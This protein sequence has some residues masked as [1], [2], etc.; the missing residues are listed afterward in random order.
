M[1]RSRNGSWRRKWSWNAKEKSKKKK[2]RLRPMQRRLPDWRKSR[3]NKK[4][5]TRKSCNASNE[6]V[7]SWSEGKDTIKINSYRVLKKK[8]VK[9]SSPLTSSNLVTDLKMSMTH[10]FHLQN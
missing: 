8:A 7:M 9:K 4:F 1:P 5:W 10:Y 3:R 6:N 2:L